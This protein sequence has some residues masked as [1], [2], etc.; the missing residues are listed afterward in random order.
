MRS[1]SEASVPPV[2]VQLAAHPL[3]WRILGEL[4]GGDRRVRELTGVIAEPQSLVS[5]HLGRL[6]AGGLVT[7]RRSSADG[8]DS[9]YSVDLARCSDLMVSA[10][11]ALH[12]GLRL[13]PVD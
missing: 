13:G 2:F 3:R 12:P 11:A 5:Y 8:R 4:A 1:A 7:A 6:R 9:Y 10:A